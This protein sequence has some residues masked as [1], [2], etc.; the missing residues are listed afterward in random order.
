MILDNEQQ[1][2]QLLV[3][4]ANTQIAGT[5]AEI[6]RIAEPIDALVQAVKKAK[7]SLSKPEKKE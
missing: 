3:C 6:C 4:I 1:R 7:V 2:E 5:Y